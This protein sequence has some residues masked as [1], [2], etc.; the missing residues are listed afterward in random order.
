MLEPFR[1]DWNSSLGLPETPFFAKTSVRCLASLVI[2]LGAAGIALTRRD[3]RPLFRDSLLALSALGI[4]TAVLAYFFPSKREQNF[5]RDLR[6]EVGAQ[7]DHGNYG[8]VAIRDQFPEALRLGVITNQDKEMLVS[9]DLVH[10]S[11]EQVD[12]RN[13]L[14]ANF[15]CF[16]LDTV[17]SL[18]RQY[19]SW[20]FDT[21]TTL[22]D[23]LN[24]DFARKFVIEPRSII[25]RFVELHLQEIEAPGYTLNQFLEQFSVDGLLCVKRSR[26]M[27]NKIALAINVGTI[28]DKWRRGLIND[29]LENNWNYYIHTLPADGSV[30]LIEDAF[31]DSET[32]RIIREK[33][34]K[35]A[36]VRRVQK[37][38]NE[39]ID[40]WSQELK[41][42]AAEFKQTED[43]AR[44][45]EIS[46]QV[47]LIQ[48]KGEQLHAQM[49][50]EMA[51]I[52]NS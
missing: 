26:A 24:T 40:L 34:E 48:V 22:G 3:I 50:A 13:N 52:V 49:L 2:A 30:L 51:A 42:L 36:E 45:K 20:K 25:P 43:E 23:I 5:L 28:D 21:A 47:N 4:T 15:E 32:L 11:F 16:S 17:L 27:Q 31:I 9:A 37:G 12:Q 10:R 7:I 33:K 6:R 1:P 8:L 18:R 44:R 14:A 29:H 41:T 39:Q 38:M 46:T 19:L 35:I